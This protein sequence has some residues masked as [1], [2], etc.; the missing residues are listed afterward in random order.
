MKDPT[1]SAARFQVNV[2]APRSGAP[3]KADAVRQVVID[4][5]EGTHTPGWKVRVA[6]WSHG[7]KREITEI[8]DSPRGAVLALTLGRALQDGRL[9]IK[10]LGNRS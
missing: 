2:T 3:H 6:V 4:W 5:L 1:P 10:P 8:D 7:R 9:Y